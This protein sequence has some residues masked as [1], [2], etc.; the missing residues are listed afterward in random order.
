MV[1]KSRYIVPKYYFKEIEED[2]KDLPIGLFMDYIPTPIDLQQN[3]FNFILLH[4][5]NE[6]FGLHDWVWKFHQNFTGIFTYNQNL[7]NDLP[8]VIPFTFGLIQSEDKKYYNSFKNKEKT[9]EVSFLSGVKDLSQGHKLRQEI[10][11][12]KD[13]INIPTKWYKVLEDF[14][15]STNVR[16]GY[17]EYSKD[18]SH[19]PEYEAPEQYGKRVLFN[20]SMFH[21]AIENVKNLNW[22]TEKI[23]QAFATKTV[24]IYWGCPNL[25]DLGYDTKGII[26]FNTKEELKDILN[27]LSP[28]DYFSRLESINHNYKVSLTDTF[29]NNLNFLLNELQKQNNLHI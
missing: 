8:N 9:F 18:I 11:N 1:I 2:F 13:Q 28:E 22:Y 14:D 21:I 23:A 6:F 10:Y 12:L 5:P 19:V 3:P 29:K 15:H 7:I 20:N 27:N 25:E 26:T 4:E 24:P 17:S 16:P